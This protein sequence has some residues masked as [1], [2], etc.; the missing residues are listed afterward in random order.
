MIVRETLVLTVMASLAKGAIFYKV[1]L[2]TGFSVHPV[3]KIILYEIVY[4]IT[5]LVS[6]IE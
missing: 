6:S 4:L 1:E 2:T 3:D 5:N